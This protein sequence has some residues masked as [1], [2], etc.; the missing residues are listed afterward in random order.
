MPAIAN[1]KETKTEGIAIPKVPE[2]ERLRLHNLFL[3]QQVCREQLNILTLQ[4][5]QTAQARAI[6]ERIDV[7]TRQIN[8]M[9]ERLFAEA[10]LD[11]LFYQ[12][13]VQEGTFIE[14]SRTVED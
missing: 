6:Q 8:E 4:F 3:Q 5:L 10:H 12:L 9:A 13:N 14:R 1:L 2:L 7:I 11:A